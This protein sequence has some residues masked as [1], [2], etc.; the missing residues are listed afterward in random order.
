MAENFN[1][2]WI[3]LCI[4]YLCREKVTLLYC[5]LDDSL[6]AKTPV[7]CVSVLSCSR[8]SCGLNIYVGDM[9]N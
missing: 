5:C 1:H 8:I 2:L 7:F 6:F 9:N 3:R 4:V